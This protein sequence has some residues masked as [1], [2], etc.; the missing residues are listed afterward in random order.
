[1]RY[2][3]L[4][5]IVAVSLCVE[6]P[7]LPFSQVASNVLTPGTLEISNEEIY[8]TAK[9]LPTEVSGGNNVTLVFQV[10]N[11]AGY[12]LEGVGLDLYDP[13]VFN[14]GDWYV[15]RPGGGTL[16]SNRTVSN[17]TTLKADPVT[18]DRDCELKFRV[19]YKGKFS[20]FQDI[21]VLTTSEYNTRLMQGTLNSLPISS[22]FSSSP[23]KISLTFT[24]EQPFLDGTSTDVQINYVYTG[25]GFINVTRGGVEIKVPENLINP[26]CKDYD[27]NSGTQT[28]SLNKELKFVSKRSTPSICTFTAKASQPLD[29]KSLILTANYNYKIDG[30]IPI[31]V[32]GTSTSQPSKTSGS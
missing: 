29:I 13:C 31:T 26:S 27:Y 23:L 15:W 10:T 1:M 3:L 11:K 8:V 24:E 14:N 17:S 25:S 28:L 4:I 5:A 20:L 32:R 21:A 18:L 30:S 22:S 19:G 6:I 2:F 12:D 9:A 7:F 16:K